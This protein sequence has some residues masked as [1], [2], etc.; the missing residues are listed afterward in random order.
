MTRVL[1]APTTWH[2]G[3]TGDQRRGLGGEG[4]EEKETKEN[5]KNMTFGYEEAILIRVINWCMTASAD[6]RRPTCQGG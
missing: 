2:Q 5:G 4:A 3:E 1:S 6:S